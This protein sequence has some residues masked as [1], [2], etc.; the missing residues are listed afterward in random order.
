ML[1][2]GMLS[3][4]SFVELVVRNLAD[5]EQVGVLQRLLMRAT[6]AVERYAAPEH[7]ERLRTSLR[8]QARSALERAEPGGDHQLAWFRHWAALAAAPEDLAVLDGLLDGVEHLPGLTVDT[9]LRWAIVIALAHAGHLD[10]VRID[11]ELARDDTDLGQR[12]AMT[13]R[14]SRPDAAAKRW[15]R[16]LLRD[17]TDLSHTIA[18]QLWAGFTQLD[19]EELA[20]DYVAEFPG[21]LDHVWGTRTLDFAIEFAAGMF[22]HAAVG[23]GL[24]EMTDTILARPDLA[25]PLR[26]AMLEQRDTVIRTARA[27]AFDALHG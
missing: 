22:P 7:R 15:A 3:A 26:R 25:K 6:S 23:A 20:A 19:Q 24:L 9:D 2:D 18:R 11:E 4:S 12:L 1:R 17:D 14:A 16:D 27:R 21:D 8:T 10:E 5:D 13:A